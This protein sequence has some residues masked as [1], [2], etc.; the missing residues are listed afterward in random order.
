MNSPHLSRSGIGAPQFTPPRR[1]RAVSIAFMVGLHLI[2]GYALVTGLANRA[3][4]WVQKPLMAVIVPEPVVPPPPPPPPAKM[5]RQVE[6]VPQPTQPPPPAFVPPPEIA[7]ATPAVTAPTITAVQISEAVATP[8]PI[9]KPAP[10]PATLPLVPP[11]PAATAKKEV[12]VACPKY[13]QILQSALDGW[14]DKVGI[15]A[16][17]KVQFKVQG[18]AVQEAVI[19]SGPREYHRPV[20]AAVRRFS[21][22]ALPGDDP[23][24]NFDIVFRS[25]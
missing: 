10:I 22:Q 19:L 1:E 9:S 11:V 25:D 16:T 17:V 23:V 14:Y 20:L 7:P 8:A 24:V 5:L 12:G 6:Q 21:C 13:A 3:V 15:A 2:V 4:T 18:N